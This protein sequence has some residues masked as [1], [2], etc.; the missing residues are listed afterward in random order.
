[1]NVSDLKI[2][3]IA[4]E[5]TRACLSL[6]CRV[7]NLTP[8]NYSM[9]LKYWKPDLIFVESAWRGYWFSWK[10]RIT[11][12]PVPNRSLIKL[13]SMARELGIP[14]VFWNKED[15]VHFEKFITSASLFDHVYTVDE[16]CIQEYRSR[17]RPSTK[18]STLTFPVQTKVHNFTGFNFKTYGANFVGSYSHHIHDK[19]RK[20][21]D[22]L[23]QACADVGMPLTIYDRNSGRRSKDFRYPILRGVQVYPAISHDKTSS[24]YKDHLISL[25]V[26]TIENSPTMFSRRLIEILACGGLAVTNPTPAVDRFFKDFCL[27]VD[28]V[29]EARELFRR[30]LKGPSSLDLERAAAGAEHVKVH[31]SW[32]GTLARLCAD[33]GI[34]Q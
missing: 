3:L 10:R 22:E 14:C 17:L 18:I 33:L 7:K 28:D 26:N 23:F 8:L 25:N 16:N 15:G 31:H 29:D 24:V 5:L 20:R 34:K 21:Q 27:T 2:G 13:V 6:E 11:Q 12:R 30:L 19:R 1:M 32:T 4:D 9:V